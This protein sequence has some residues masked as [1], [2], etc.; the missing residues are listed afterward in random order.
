MKDHI[1]EV[2]NT[3]E[4]QYEESTSEMKLLLDKIATLENEVKVK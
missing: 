2:N 3:V 1:M 4:T